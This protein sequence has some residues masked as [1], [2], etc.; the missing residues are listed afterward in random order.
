MYVRA[1]VFATYT[2]M[3]LDFKSE[4]DAEVSP[5]TSLTSIPS[6]SINFSFQS[7]NRSEQSALVGAMYTAFAAGFDESSFTRASSSTHVLPD[8]VGELTTKEAALS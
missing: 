3:E 2:M 6:F 7:S 1:C 4:A 5:V 8:P